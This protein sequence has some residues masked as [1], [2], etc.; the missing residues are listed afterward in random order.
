MGQARRLRALEAAPAQRRDLLRAALALLRLL[1]RATP[2]AAAPGVR[3]DARLRA[4]ALLLRRV[5]HAAHRQ[6]RDPVRARS[7]SSASTPTRATGSLGARS[8]SRACAIAGAVL[9]RQS[10]LWL[11]RW[12][13]S[14]L[15]R[16]AGGQVLAGA[17]LLALAL[18]PLAAL[19]I[20]WDGLVPPGADPLSCGLC[21]DRPGSAARR[22]RCAP[23]ASRLRCSAPTRRWCWDAACGR[24][25]ACASCAVRRAGWRAARC[26]APA[27]QALVSVVRARRAAP[28][29][30]A[31]LALIAAAGVAVLLLIS[32]LDYLPITPGRAGDAGWLWSISDALP[33]LLGSSLLFWVL[34]PLGAVAARCSCAAPGRVARCRASTWARSCSRRCPWGSSTRSTSTRS[35]CSPW[36]CSRGAATFAGAPTTRA[37]RLSAWRFVAYALS[38]A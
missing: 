16:R 22:S 2:L 20:E 7:R 31:R 28:A 34:V 37:S 17:A 29:A 15:R 6:P 9:T 27:G 13:R 33:E 26:A 1:R 8:R 10:F 21:A 11:C 12:P 36:R 30:G 32:P 35:C 24:I 18:A 4:L 14:L 3:A 5:V 25:A 19:V 38:F 23:S